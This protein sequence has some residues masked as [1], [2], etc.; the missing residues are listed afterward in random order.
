MSGT[1]ASPAEGAWIVADM[2]GG[3]LPDAAG[4]LRLVPATPAP[5]A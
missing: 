4:A 5:T 1:P 3:V 2:P